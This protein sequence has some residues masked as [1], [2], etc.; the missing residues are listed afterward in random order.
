M[1]LA[2]IMLASSSC[3]NDDDK[4]TTSSTETTLRTPQYKN[5]AVRMNLPPNRL[6]VDGQEANVNLIELAESGTYLIAYQQ[7]ATRTA[8][9]TKYRTGSYTKNGN[10]YNLTGF[11]TV[12]INGKSG[13]TYTIVVK[14][15]DGTTTELSATAA[16]GGVAS[17]TMTDNLCRTWTI[18]K[19]RLSVTVEGITAA[20][21]FP[22]RCD[23]NKLIDYAKER[24]LKIDDKVEENSIVS[25]ITFSQAGTFIIS[26]QNGIN[27]VGKW[28][29]SNPSTGA[30]SYGWESSDMGNSLENGQATV[31]FKD[32]KCKLTLG[33]TIN[34]Y[35][36]Q[37]EYTLVF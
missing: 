4:D 23:L 20:K 9:N 25:G 33:A 35:P 7:N 30:L 21:E 36:I 1:A 24:G 16:S 29:W 14:T 26:Y 19:T 34:N 13:S 22:G 5:D 31:S 32:E 17:G 18:E 8:D 37:L 27:D 6:I 10:A 2:V 15:T 11:A 12:T 28:K 3:S